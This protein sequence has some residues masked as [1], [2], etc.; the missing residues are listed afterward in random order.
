MK[1]IAVIGSGTMGHGI[2][3]VCAMAG[4][5]VHLYDLNAEAL[6][7]ALAK[8]TA[9]LDKGI[10]RG[11]VTTEQRDTTLANLAVSADFAQAV[12]SNASG[13][14]EYLPGGHGVAPEAPSEGT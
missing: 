7:R 11:K 14:S 3:Q 13:A 12:Q 6:E 1:N 4:Y 5:S 9:N 10:A 2:A 8:V